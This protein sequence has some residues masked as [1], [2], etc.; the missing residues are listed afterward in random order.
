[1]LQSVATLIGML[2]VAPLYS[3]S[4]LRERPAPFDA[5]LCFFALSLL[6]FVLY[7]L[8][9]SLQLNVVGEFVEPTPVT[10]TSRRKQ[11]CAL[12]GDAVTVPVSDITALLGDANM[13]FAR[14]RFDSRSFDAGLEMVSCKN[15]RK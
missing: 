7:V 8:S 5:S 15:G 14:E 9:F 11:T 4:T 10:G 3:W 13:S 2:I 6:S 12:F 1:M